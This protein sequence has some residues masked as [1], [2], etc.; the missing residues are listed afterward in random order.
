[1]SES[2]LKKAVAQF[3]GAVEVVFHE[4]WDYSRGHDLDRVAGSG[5]FLRPGPDGVLSNWGAM[6]AFYEAYERLLA[7][8]K[9]SGIEPDLPQRDD[10]FIFDWPGECGGDS[11]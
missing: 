8:L 7:S 5:T 6:V 1:M 2:S 11:D 9:E 10:W 4:D 3:V